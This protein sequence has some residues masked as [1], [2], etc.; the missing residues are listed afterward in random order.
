[1]QRSGAVLLLCMTLATNGIVLAKP[2]AEE[3]EFV[4]D[5]SSLS[6][7][8]FERIALE[9]DPL[10]A[11][12]YQRGEAARHRAIAV[13][14]LPDPQVRIG[15]VNVPIDSFSTTE[16]DMTM[17]EVG[18]QQS[19][20][21][22]GTLTHSRAEQEAMAASEDAM[23]AERELAVLRGV[24]EAWLELYF[25]F[26]AVALVQKTQHV[27]GELVKVSTARYRSGRG[28]QQEVLRAEL[29]SSKLQDRVTTMELEKDVLMT[30]LG[31]WIGASHVAR[32]SPVKFPDLPAVPGLD[33]IRAKL[34]EHPM[35]QAAEA[36]VDV[37]REGVELARSEYRPMS[38][39]DVAYGQRGGERSD[40]M[41]AMLSFSVPIF[42]SKRQDRGLQARRAEVI[43]TKSETEVQRRELQEILES[44]YR[45]LQRLD[46]R[47]KLYE[48]E[49]LPYSAQYAQ[50]SLTSYQSGVADFEDHVMARMA[51]LENGMEALRIKVDRAKT[52]ARLLYIYG[53]RTL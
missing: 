26:Q 19:F 6:F 17:K 23:S 50:S 15:M 7:R 14:Q 53:D 33:L 36:R 43:A 1:M 31:R 12:T 35:L 34:R 16:E 45:R 42:T 22:Y 47:A 10:T 48:K 20:P 8:E 5:L 2:V 3:G 28:Q 13:S 27:F 18:F 32:P 51:E 29:E 25:Q 46:E 40:M 52:Q 11:T 4:L 21:P 37:A 24:R 30:E 49:V 41:S 44:D 38:M 39:I 9:A